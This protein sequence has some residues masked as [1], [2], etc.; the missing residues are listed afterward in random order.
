MSKLRTRIADSLAALP[1]SAHD[2]WQ[3]EEPALQF[4][5]TL[6]WS[7]LLSKHA[8]EPDERERIVCVE[9]ESGRC[10]ALLP[11]K[12]GP[13]SGFAGL[14]FA[15]ALA[16]YYSSLYTPIVATGADR[17]AV[18][19]ALCGALSALDPSVDALDLNP[20]P[21]GPDGAEPL[22]AQLERSGWHVEQY[23]R[24]G[25]WYL[26]V[27]GRSYATYFQ[28][29][30]SQLRNTVTRKAK[31]LLA[32]PG[33]ALG[34]ARTVDEAERALLDYEQCYAASWKKPEPHPQFVPSLIRYLAARGWLRLGWVRLGE[35]PIAAQ[36]WSVKD[37]VASI[38]KLAYDENFAQLS[39]GS[40]L[41]SELMRHALDVDKVRVVDY[42]TGDDSYKRDWMSHRRERVG[43]RAYR[44]SSLRG[45]LFV[46]VEAAARTAK[47]LRKP[48]P[49]P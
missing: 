23:F 45:K 9:D 19:A 48:S 27:A 15:R 25:N 38:F 6:G 42:L 47:R 3:R 17:A 28:G 35:Q 5:Q 2:L 12:T 24:F 8:R 39:A 30:K 26:E 10:V 33:A 14:R 36:I 4:D 7:E 34:I 44:R 20:L 43:L 32:Q 29:L 21:E 11:L 49:S 22:K 37:G 41:T 46:A 18:L 1:D 13:R 31:K 40:V 16:N